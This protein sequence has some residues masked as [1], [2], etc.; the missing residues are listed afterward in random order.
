MCGEIKFYIKI[1]LIIEQRTLQSQNDNFRTIV[2]RFCALT[3]TQHYLFKLRDLSVRIS[4]YLQGVGC[5]NMQRIKFRFL[6]VAAPH[7]QQFQ[8]HFYYNRFA[9]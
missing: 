8:I 4:L 6:C 1:Y 9:K 3:P 7:V 2:Q 5:Y